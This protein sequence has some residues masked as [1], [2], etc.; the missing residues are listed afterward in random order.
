MSGRIDN[1]P[2]ALLTNVI[3]HIGR[4]MQNWPSTKSASG[5]AYAKALAEE[6]VAGVR[7]AA[8]IPVP[9][10]LIKRTMTALWGHGE[11]KLLDELGEFVKDNVVSL[12]DTMPDPFT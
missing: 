2:Q 7:G 6:A 11:D 10:D 1:I 8:Y 3:K 9:T 4:A 12:T 5:H